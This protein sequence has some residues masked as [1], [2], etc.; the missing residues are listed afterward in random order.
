MKYIKKVKKEALIVSK[1]IGL[2]EGYSR[3]KGQWT[4]LNPIRMAQR[5]AVK[6]YKKLNRLNKRKNNLG[7]ILKD[8]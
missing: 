5:K 2:T 8:E 7:R 1:R 4:V 3:V 6:L